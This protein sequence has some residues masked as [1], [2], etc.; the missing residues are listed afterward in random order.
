MHLQRTPTAL[1]V[2]TLFV[3]AA[4]ALATTA[5]FCAVGFLVARPR[6]RAPTALASAAFAT[7]WHSAAV[8]SASQGL[9]LLAAALGEDTMALVVALESLTT[10]FYC[11]AAASLLYYVLFLFTGKQ[12]F[13]TPIAIYYLA[14][15]PLL[16]YQVARADPIGYTVTPWQVSY[17]YAQ[18]LE[19]WGYSLTLALVVTPVLAAVC[20]YASLVAR[21]S[22]PPTRYR[23]TCVTVGLALWVSIEALSFASGLADTAP[24]EILRRLVGIASATAVVAGYAPPAYARRRWGAASFPKAPPI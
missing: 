10:P 20:T 8:V 12:E 24:G 15:L 21:V 9:R 2:P 17:V 5:G 16:R 13:A 11:L 4:L 22:D 14:L 6:S 7:F 19:W 3:S 18:P 1:P 23:A